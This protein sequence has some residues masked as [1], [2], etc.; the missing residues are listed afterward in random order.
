MNTQAYGNE[1]GLSKATFL[2]SFSA[3]VQKSVQMARGGLNS[4][5]G[6]VEGIV[7]EG[8]ISRDKNNGRKFWFTVVYGFNHIN[9]IAELWEKLKEYNNNC[10]EAWAIG[11]DF[12]NVLKFQERIGSD[13]TAAEILPFQNCVSWCQLQDI[14]A[15]GSYFTWN[16][17]QGAV[18]RVYSRIDRLMVNS[19]WINHYPEAFANFLP[20]GLYDHCPCIVH[21]GEVVGRKRAPFKYYN[22]WSMSYEFEKTRKLRHKPLDPELIAVERT[23]AQEYAQ[24]MKAKHSFLMQKS[25]ADWAVE[26][27]DNTAYFHASLRSRRSKNKVIQIVD[28]HGDCQTDSHGINEAFEEYFTQILWTN[29]EVMRVHM[30]TVRRGKLITINMHSILLKPVTVDEIKQAMYSIPGTK[31]PGPDGYTSQFFK[32]SWDLTG[33]CV[34]AAI[35]DFFN[36]G[37]LLKKINN[38]VLILIPKIDRP[39]CVT[40]FRPIACCNT[41]YKCIIRLLCNRLGAVLPHIISP[42]QSAFVKGRVIVENILICQDLVRLYT[43]KACSPRVMIKVDLQKAYDSIEWAFLKDMLNALQFRE[44]FIQLIMECVSTPSF[45]IALNGEFFL[46]LMVVQEKEGFKFHPLCK[47]LALSHLCFADDLL[48]NGVPKEIITEIIHLAGI[49]EDK[50]P[51]RYLGVRISAKR[52]SALDCAKLVDKISSLVDSD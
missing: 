11:G 17:K 1:T 25:K 9:S 13:V 47:P 49:V 27:D 24:L 50:L 43:R 35:L 52:L 14:P 22:I 36:H 3:A 23:L 42:N 34:T 33:E 10:S 7:E 39:V 31:A 19:E 30:P 2:D 38:T 20:E 51:F 12:N 41:I 28:I 21:F 40:Q 8:S 32:D 37:K 26:G 46:V 5:R 29:K 48:F 15:I 18:I 44:M 16:N 4:R 6:V 45:S